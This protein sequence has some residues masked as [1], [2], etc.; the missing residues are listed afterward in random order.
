[1][2]NF[3]VRCLNNGV[4]VSVK[5][6][7]C[8]QWKHLSHANTHTH[9]IHGNTYCL[10]SLEQG[11]WY[12][13]A[14]MIHLYTGGRFVLVDI[15]AGRQCVLCANARETDIINITN[16]ILYMRIVRRKFY[17]LFWLLNKSIF[18]FHIKTDYSQYFVWALST[19]CE[20][21]CAIVLPCGKETDDFYRGLQV[22]VFKVRIMPWPFQISRERPKISSSIGWQIKFP[23]YFFIVTFPSAKMLQLILFSTSSILSSKSEVVQSDTTF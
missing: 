15:T 9:G 6:R 2:T 5:N 13:V 3:I 20:L 11:T 1:M 17:L 21:H 4:Y 8:K 18:L 22:N 14:F 16:R 19:G 23:Y 12:F 7:L 10:R